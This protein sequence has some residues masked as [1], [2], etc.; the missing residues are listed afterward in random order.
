MLIAATASAVP[1]RTAPDEPAEALKPVSYWKD[2]RPVFQARCQGCHQPAKAKGGFVMTDFAA[3]V[4]G[5]EDEGPAVVPGKPDDSSIV[6]N[7]TPDPAGEASMPKNADPLQPAEIALVRRWIEQGATDDTPANARQVWNAEHPPVYTKAPLV[8]ALDFSPD[9]RL[10]AVSGFHEVILVNTAT[11]ELAARLIGLS[12]RIESVH[13]SPD[14]QRLAVT[15]GQP[16]RMGEVQVWDV[17][18]AKLA[19]SVP[20]TFDTLYGG[21]WSP[22]GSLIVFGGADKSVRVIDATSGEQKFFS[23]LHDDW[24]QDTVFSVKGDYLVSVG[25]DMA[26]KL[27]EFATQRFVDNITSITPGAL[28]GGLQAVSR[29]PERDEILVA[30]SDG[31]P[32]L[33]RLYRQVERKIGDDSNLIRVFPAIAGRIWTAE[34]APN[35]K[36]FAVGG[37]LDGKGVVAFYSC[38]IDSALPEELKVIFRKE[39]TGRNAEEKRKVDDFSR[40]GVSKLREVSLPGAV[41]ALSYT[42]DG[43]QVACAGADGVVRFLNAADGAILREVRP[44]PLT[45][46]Q[47]SN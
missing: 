26:A 11:G 12:E 45:A 38:D 28:K 33:Y 40:A 3:L 18:T 39:I 7:I 21:A 22:D 8:S 46:V 23:I 27:S 43:T 19:L 9:G 1:G 35:A 36:T 16:A 2:I 4:K 41:Y 32:R 29:H 6:R 44:F 42:P 5:G 13:F 15:G 34:Y 47:A 24:V 25:R 37:S 31:E 14:G 30:G 17:G 20:A 10:L